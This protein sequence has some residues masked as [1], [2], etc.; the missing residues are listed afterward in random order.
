MAEAAPRHGGA[1]DAVVGP[2]AGRDATRRVPPR[3]RARSRI[4]TTTERDTTPEPLLPPCSPRRRN[5]DP[6]ARTVGSR[7]ALYDLDVTGVCNGLPNMRRVQTTQQKQCGGS[8]AYEERID[9]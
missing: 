6:L 1:H 3:T 5:P 4:R 2:G 9:G 8:P 7:T